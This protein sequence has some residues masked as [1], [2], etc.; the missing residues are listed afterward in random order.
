MSVRKKRKYHISDSAN[1]HK[2][3]IILLIFLIL[4]I[5]ALIFLFEGNYIIPHVISNTALAKTQLSPGELLKGTLSIELQKGDLLP[6]NTEIYLSITNEE[7][8]CQTEYL[9]SN[10]RS[11]PWRDL[12]NECSPIDPDPE[13]TCCRD[14]P[15]TCTQLILNSGFETE[16]QPDWWLITPGQTTAERID[17]DYVEGDY[18]LKL[19]SSEAVS[20]TQTKAYQT[21]KGARSVKI[22]KFYN[23]DD[24]S[25]TSDSA[26]GDFGTSDT[27]GVFGNVIGEAHQTYYSLQY[28]FKYYETGADGPCAFEV[29]VEGNTPVGTARALHYYYK[30]NNQCSYTESATNKYILINTPDEADWITHKRDLYADWITKGFTDDDSVRKIYLISHG[31][32]N[33]AQE[34]YFDEVNLTIVGA[35]ERTCIEYG[36][37][38]C[39]SQTGSGNYYGDQF[40]CTETT[41]CWDS[42][43]TPTKLELREFISRSEERTK[44][45]RTSGDYTYI[46][47][48][49]D[50]RYLGDDSG[51]GYAACLD[52]STQAKA[53]CR[54]WNNIYH[55]NMTRLAPGLEAPETNGTYKLY[56]AIKYKPAG[57]EDYIIMSEQSTIFFVG[58][59]AGPCNESWTCTNWNSC[60]L[61]DTQIRNCTDRR[62]CGTVVYK[63]EI[64][65]TCCVEDWDCDQWDSCEGQ[66]RT[67]I[68]ADL[69]TCDTLFNKPNTTWY[70]PACT[71][72][73]TSSDWNCNEWR[74]CIDGTQTRSCTKINSCDEQSGYTPETEK[75]C[76]GLNLGSW[77]IWVLL[78]L[79]LVAVVIVLLVKVLPTIGRKK[80]TIEPKAGENSELVGYIKDALA[81]GSSNQEIKQK[82]SEAGWP[83][84]SIDSA[85]KK[86]L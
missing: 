2:E 44:Y 24:T 17:D 15:S 4:I 77:W 3:K 64:S 62:E 49:G 22:S 38:C 65:R 70:D 42:C 29:V 74:G 50:K 75:S 8:P 72:P 57:F 53:S 78:I 60:S 41:E 5:V 40:E 52:T 84:A 80:K 39:E 66:F 63:P 54:E 18:S 27:D 12:D 34:V 67:R 35:G 86:A 43:L 31:K 28:S 37:K 20:L 85:F 26:P 21:L 48:N 30:L 46:N 51:E 68:C 61:G 71:Q 36:A 16:L 56:F 73:C 59:S 55:L 25:E 7:E 58:T 45:N 47:E 13:S 11:I 1:P 9:C 6:T 81:S 83:K 76:S 32:T 82:L 19:D 79:V 23:S 69:N 14:F 33:Y 10:G